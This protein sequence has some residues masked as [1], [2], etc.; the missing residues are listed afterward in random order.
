VK[1][2][3]FYIVVLLF[4]LAYIEVA[5]NKDVSGRTDDL[6]ALVPAKSDSNAGSWKTILLTG[7]AEFPVPAPIA[8]NTPDYIAQINEIKSA[9]ATITAEEKAIIKY[10]TA[11]GVLRWNEILRE[12]VAKHNLP[13]YQNDDGSYPIPIIHLPIRSFR[14]Q[15]RPTPHVPT[16]MFLPH[17]TMRLLL[18]GISKSNT[19]ARL[20]TAL[21]APSKYL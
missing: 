16:V 5:C 21:T 18:P 4:P 19:G 6:S 7:P 8:T 1:K 17:N 15:I 2:I 11:G 12:L 13:P 20:L 10:W 3:S 14:F 9:Q